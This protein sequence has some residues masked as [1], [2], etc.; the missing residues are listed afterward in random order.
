YVSCALAIEAIARASATVAVSLSVTNCLVAE[1]IAHAGRAPHKEQWLRRLAAGE[2]I[3]A[4]ALSEPDAGTDAANQKTKAVR[5][6]SGYRITGRKVWVDNA[7][8]AS[9][10]VLFA[11]TREGLRGQGVTAFLVPMETPGIVRRARADS[12]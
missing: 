12:L 6:G 2:A 5:T 11:C 9:L 8:G 4:F 1:L 3:G 10:V 7:D